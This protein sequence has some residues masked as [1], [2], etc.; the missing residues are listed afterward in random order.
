M[1][2]FRTRDAAI[3]SVITTRSA[4]EPIK[5]II[6]QVRG[7]H[8]PYRFMSAWAQLRPDR[9][10]NAFVRIDALPAECRCDFAGG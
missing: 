5:V 8:Q 6:V 2:F 10:L 7:Y 9:E 1:V 3:R 4:T